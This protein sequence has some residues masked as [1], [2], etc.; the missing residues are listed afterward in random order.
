MPGVL[1]A[2]QR[3]GARLEVRHQCGALGASD[4]AA[5]YAERGVQAS[6][7]P[8]LDDLAD[9]YLWAHFVV[10][11]A[12][13]GTLAELALAGLPALIVP[14][15]DAAADHQSANA[16]HHASA[17]AALWCRESDWDRHGI[18]RD[19][20]DLLSSRPRWHAMTE[21]ARRLARPD[22]AVQVVDDC[23]RLMEGRW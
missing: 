21:A 12:G 22:A 17:G 4:L 3:L 18:A 15:A 1:A 6:V 2:V 14:L 9:A 19:V 20:F 16:M 7:A 13:A 10:A 23:Q 5:A 11:R 8:F